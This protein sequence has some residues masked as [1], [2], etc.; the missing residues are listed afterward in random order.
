MFRKILILILRFLRKKKTKEEI[1]EWINSK[2]TRFG[3]H[4][5]FMLTYLGSL[6]QWRYLDMRESLLSK[7]R[8]YWY[9][10]YWEN[11]TVKERMRENKVLY[12]L[13]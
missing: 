11:L 10:Q 6:N 5:N 7:D 4:E 12:S 8:S 13:T 9:H 3:M 2:N 1:L